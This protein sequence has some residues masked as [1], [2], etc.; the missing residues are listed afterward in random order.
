MADPKA[1]EATKTAILTAFSQGKVKDF[2]KSVERAGLRIRHFELV[3]RKGLL[4]SD[5]PK[6][7]DRLTPSDQGQIRELYLASLEK[8]APELRAEYFK[9]YAYY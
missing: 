6:E 1:F 7:Y 2:L 3:L 8:V 5:T 4:G 9:V